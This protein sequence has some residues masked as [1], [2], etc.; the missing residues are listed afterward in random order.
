MEPTQEPR[1]SKLL[2]VDCH[3]PPD[4]FETNWGDDLSE[5]A[6]AWYEDHSLACEGTGYISAYCIGCPF[7]K[8]DEE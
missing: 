8:W 5:D 7:V 3:A 1:D 6:Q 4:L 2:F